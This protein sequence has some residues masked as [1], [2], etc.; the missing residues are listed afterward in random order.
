MIQSS[1]LFPTGI[2]PHDF[3]PTINQIQTVDSAVLMDSR[4]ASVVAQE[5]PDGKI[6]VLSPIGGLT[7]YDQEVGIAYIDKINKNIKNLRVGLEY[8]R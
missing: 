8:N 1:I 6:L 4:Y 5:I 2:D 7:K 3:D